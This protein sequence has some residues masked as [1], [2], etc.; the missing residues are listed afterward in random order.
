MCQKYKPCQ[1]RCSRHHTKALLIAYMGCKRCR[2]RFYY[3]PYNCTVRSLTRRG[4]PQRATFEIEN[5]R[6]VGSWCFWLVVVLGLPACLTAPLP[7]PDFMDGV[8]WL[9]GGASSDPT[10]H[11][12]PPRRKKTLS[13]D[14]LIFFLLL[15]VRLTSQQHPALTSAQYT[16]VLSQSRPQRSLILTQIRLNLL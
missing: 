12:I 5:M 9:A 1:A 14:S 16:A 10:C 15:Q 13:A 2:H 6:R 7:A 11:T 3:G 8:V 4:Q